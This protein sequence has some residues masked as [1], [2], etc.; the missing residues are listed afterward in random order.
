[1]HFPRHF[2]LVLFF[3]LLSTTVVTASLP[4]S[5]SQSS[6]NKVASSGALSR[7]TTKPAASHSTS[8]SKSVPSG[9]TK[10]STKSS[11]SATVTQTGTHNSSKGGKLSTGAIA[12]I[13]GGCIGAAFGVATVIILARSCY[14]RRRAK[15][16]KAALIA[17]TAA[18]LAGSGFTSGE[19]K[20][21]SPALARVDAT[22]DEY[23]KPEQ[24]QFIGEQISVPQMNRL[25]S[26]QATPTVNPQRFSWFDSASSLPMYNNPPRAPSP[27]ASY[28]MPTPTRSYS[29]TPSSPENQPH[30]YASVEGL[31]SPYPA[32]LQHENTSDDQRHAT[33]QQVYIPNRG[34]S[35]STMTL[36][37]PFSD[38]GHS[39]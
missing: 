8:A 36:P 33:L 35:A 16:Y 2:V 9:E 10:P 21:P 12:K 28:Q 11:S 38:D 5:A 19:P 6:N 22:Q 26:N 15:R 17:N 24:P 29:S 32:P 23:Q 34:P 37:N 30:M 25:Q 3:V 4:A 1:M 7:T 18:A 13:V 39:P 14:A 20:Y 27:A 31:L